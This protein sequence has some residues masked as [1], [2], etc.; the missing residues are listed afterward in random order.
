MK[1]FRARKG[2]VV[3]G[4]GTLHPTVPTHYDTTQGPRAGEAAGK[5]SHGPLISKQE[6]ILS[7]NRQVQR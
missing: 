3:P 6:Q 2:Q 1:R 7:K 4:S 5:G